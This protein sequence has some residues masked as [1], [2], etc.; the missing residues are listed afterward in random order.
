VNLFAFAVRWDAKVRSL[1][2]KKLKNVV[3][4]ELQT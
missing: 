1:R 3:L 4:G 2:S